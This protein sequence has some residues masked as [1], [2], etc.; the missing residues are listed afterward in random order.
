[1]KINVSILDAIQ[2]VPSYAK[3]LKDMCTK[4]RKTNVA[5]KIIL[6]TNISELLCDP[7]PVKYKNLGYPTITCTIGQ[8]K[9]SHALLDLRA[10]INFL[11][12]LVYQ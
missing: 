6:A 10:S 11:S 8:T 1:V 9:I 12:F 5:K 2:Q 4:K 3:F 7:I